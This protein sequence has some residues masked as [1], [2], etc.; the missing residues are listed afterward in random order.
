MNIYVIVENGI[1]I[2]RTQAEEA[3]A[4]NWIENAEAQIGWSYADGVFSPPSPE[5]APNPVTQ[6]MTA[7]QTRLVLL[8]AGLLDDVESLVSGM[9][10]AAQ[11]EWEYATYIER[12]N[13][14][15]AE[16][17]PMLGFSDEQMDDLFRTGAAL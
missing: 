5:P 10:R 8:G 9:S 1:V 3:L 13:V 17:Q 11:I 7:R 16:A 14:L 2:N 15:I 6:S 12:D 4:Y